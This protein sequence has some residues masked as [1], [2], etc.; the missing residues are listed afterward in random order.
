MRIVR[1]E[2][3]EDVVVGVEVEVDGVGVSQDFSPFFI[4]LS[5]TRFH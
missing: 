3:F 4:F 5:Y 1:G 2:S